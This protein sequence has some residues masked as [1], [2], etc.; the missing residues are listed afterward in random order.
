[1]EQLDRLRN[2]YH[3]TIVP[4]PQKSKRGA[5]SKTKS[6]IA[7]LSKQAT[8][9]SG[10]WMQIVTMVDQLLRPLTNNDGKR[11]RGKGLS[12]WAEALVAVLH[13]FQQRSNG[14]HED[15][16]QDDRPQPLFASLKAT[17]SVSDNL[18][19][20]ILD[21][22]QLSNGPARAGQMSFDVAIKGLQGY[23]E[24]AESLDVVMDASSAIDFLV[25]R[26]QDLPVV[27][28][29]VGDAVSI[30]GWLDLALD[31]A[32]HLV[33]LGF[34]H[35]YV[36]RSISA[37]AYLPGTLRTRLKIADNERRLARDAYALQLMSKTRLVDP[38]RLKLL[39]G[40]SGID[41]GPTPPSRLLAMADPRDTVRRMQRLL[42]DDESANES[43]DD[44]S[45]QH[46]E[47]TDLS[48]LPIPSLPNHPPKDILSVT[49]FRDYLACPYR[50]FLRHVLGLKP[51]DDASRELAANQFGDLI[52]DALE[53]FGKDTTVRD[54]ENPDRI[55]EFLEQHFNQLAEHRYG[56]TA[57]AAVQ[58]QIELARSRLR[59]AADQQAAWRGKGWLIKGAEA[60]VHGLKPS[61]GADN[62]V[63]DAGER[64]VAEFMV[65]GEPMA[66]SGR[67]DRVDHN[68]ITQQ[69]AIIDYKT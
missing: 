69:W 45:M 43:P 22:P 53:R 12:Q 62:P 2:D 25:G 17:S 58:L 16:T 52:H 1:M 57:S 44:S 18:L 14:M 4:R 13:R 39:V 37:D 10:D 29:A 8:D 6:D 49:A 3:P 47:D 50:F 5:T 68:P 66:L 26:L 55:R 21:N 42:G 60:A 46:N 61:Q 23:R 51:L 63:T 9:S 65:D 27:P 48:A 32:R 38:D 59:V 41:D 54:E 40:A 56:Q 24:L 19:P 30:V 36:P 15:E 64:R 33:V 31:D 11:S 67:F 7:G 35:P 28:S 34:N 20:G